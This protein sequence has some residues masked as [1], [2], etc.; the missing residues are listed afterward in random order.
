M[1]FY[2]FWLYEIHFVLKVVKIASIRVLFPTKIALL[3]SKLET[4][5]KGVLELIRNESNKVLVDEILVGRSF[6]TLLCLKW[7]T[8]VVLS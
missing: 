3:R 7:S 6:L 2:R 8:K 1:Q 5:N 4:P